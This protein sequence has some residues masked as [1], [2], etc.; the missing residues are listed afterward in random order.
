MNHYYESWRFVKQIFPLLIVGVFLAGMV[1]VLIPPE[2]I[3]SIAGQNTVLANLAGVV[4]GVFMY[5]PTL[6]EVPI[7]NMFLALGMHRGPLLAYLI[8]DPA[9]S[10]QSILITVKVI[11]SKRT[12][13][14]V[15]LVA[16]FSTLA[17]LI[18]GAWVNGASTWLILSGLATFLGL[19]AV[20]LWL[21]GRRYRQ[22]MV[23]AKSHPR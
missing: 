2:L 4:F 18:Y 14:Y 20:S 12:W 15:G 23:S 6:V 17:G 8:A 10:I 5:F 22:P 19:L 1:R 16:L 7:A 11:G 13:V 3:Q 9:L 21:V